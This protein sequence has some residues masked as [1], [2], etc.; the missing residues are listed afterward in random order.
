MS[1][2]S[3]RRSIIA[4]TTIS[5]AED[6]APRRERFVG[7]DDHRALFVAGGDEQEHQVRGLRVN[8]DVADLA[9]VEGTDLLV[10][11]ELTGDEHRDALE[12]SQLVV[13]TAV[14]LGIAEAGH[15]SPWQQH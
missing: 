12:L 5:S 13:E 15:R 10:V 7:G 4:T 9:D 8:R 11:R 3:P 14:A 6:L 1:A 2:W